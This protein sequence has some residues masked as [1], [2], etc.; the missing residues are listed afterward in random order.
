MDRPLIINLAPTGAVADADK[1]PNVPITTASIVADVG[2]C[3]AEGVSIAHVH[4]R[5]DT[6]APSCDPALFA[7]VFEGV[8]TS[9]TCADTVLCASTSGRHGQTIAQ[10]T[11]VLHLPADVRPDMASLTLGSL[12]FMTG[13]SVNAPDTI[14][15]LL[16]HMN[17][18]EVKPELEVFDAGMIEFAKVLIREDRIRPPYYFNLLLGNIGGLQAS[19]QH[20]GFA[21]SILPPDSLVSIAGIG[22]FQT[23]ANGLGAVACDG[24][25][26]GLEDNLWMDQRTREPASNAMLTRRVVDVCKALGRPI[27]TAAQTREMLGLPAR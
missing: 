25:R 26:V 21:L 15:A 19:P 5:S 22:R 3:A 7:R 20:L 12:N 1:N 27:A 6:G 24:V 14:R 13:P 4:V 23:L 16:D 8:R 17:E 9:N 18:A 11:A 10:R 2:A